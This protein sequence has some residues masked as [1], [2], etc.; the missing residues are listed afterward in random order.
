MKNTAEVIDIK[1]VTTKQ[2][3]RK[4]FTLKLLSTGQ[5]FE[6]WSR[7]GF[8]P[9]QGQKLEA[10]VTVY[11]RAYI[12]KNGKPRVKNVVGVNWE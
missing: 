9:K 1:T 2:G 7:I 12:D 11:A 6:E 10:C 4:I 3:E 5:T 8:E